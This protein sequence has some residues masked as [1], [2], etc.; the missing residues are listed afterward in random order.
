MPVVCSFLFGGCGSECFF[1]SFQSYD[2]I[3]KLN[4]CAIFYS[5]CPNFQW[6]WLG[7][8]GSV[9]LVVWEVN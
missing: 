1:F 3:E 8:C 4:L 6:G 5:C 2:Q 9:V 7:E